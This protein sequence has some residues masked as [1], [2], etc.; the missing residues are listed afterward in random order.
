M[1]LY[2]HPDEAKRPAHL[3]AGKAHVSCGILCPDN[4]R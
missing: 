2:L 1:N 3:I 4:L